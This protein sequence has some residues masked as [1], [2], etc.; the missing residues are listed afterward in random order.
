MTGQLL[1]SEVQEFIKDHQNDDP[2]LLSLSAKKGSDF[3]M[4]LAIEQIQSRQKAKDKLPDWLKVEGILLPPPVS[5]E[6]SSSSITA[7]YKASLTFGVSLVDL[8][9]GMGVDASF[10][11]DRFEKVTYVEP[12][13]RLCNLARHNF[14]V[15][16]KRIEV[17]QFTAESFLED[18]KKV[19]DTIFID[20]SRRIDNRKVF[21]IEDCEPNLYEIFPICLERAKHVLVK[22]S[23]LVDL[24]LLIRNFQPTDL[25]IV[26][27]KGEVKEV[28]CLSSNEKKPVK[29]HSVDL[30]DH[31]KNVVFEFRWE[32]E[33]AAQNEYSQP[34][35]YIYEPNAAILKAGAFKLLGKRF[36]LKKLHQHT[37]LYTSEDFVQNF[38]GK[39]LEVKQN[40][41][42]SKKEMLKAIPGKKINIIARNFPFSPV[43]LKNRFDLKDGGDQFLIGTTL[44][45]NKKVLL[46]CDRLS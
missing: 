14:K 45:D 35:K 6:Q 33:Q 21:R 26:A 13:E 39:T 16:G 3:P 17:C 12:N 23:P 30:L 10:F 28:L 7:R 11:A 24:S 18:N 2:F 40:I 36:N 38:P 8:T 41:S 37:H 25:W 31:E 19:F 43:Q 15:L 44:L 27:V 46:L 20:P 29:I 22:L 42:Q 9:G 34:L 4:E 1:S 5:V 32:E